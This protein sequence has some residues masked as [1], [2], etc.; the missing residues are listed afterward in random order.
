M[1]TAEVIV[2]SI[3]SLKKYLY[4]HLIILSR[5]FFRQHWRLANVAALE[6]PD[7]LSVL[8]VTKPPSAPPPEGHFS[9]LGLFIPTNH[10]TAPGAQLLDVKS[11]APRLSEFV[12]ATGPATSRLVRGARVPTPTL[13]ELVT[14]IPVLFG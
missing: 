3:R 1:G 13:P 2:I 10:A 5:C 4:A 11:V 6:Y 8:V 12:T 7:S 14:E 9:T